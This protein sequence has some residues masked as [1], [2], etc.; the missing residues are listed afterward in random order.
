MII[1]ILGAGAYGTALGEILIKNGHN[2]RYYDP[3]FGRDDFID[4]ESCENW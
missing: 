4:V 3:K 1:A 2:V